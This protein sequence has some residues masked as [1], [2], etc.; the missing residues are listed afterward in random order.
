MAFPLGRGVR[1][2]VAPP[3][4][5]FVSWSVKSPNEKVADRLLN[6]PSGLGKFGSNVNPLSLCNFKTGDHDVIM[7]KVYLPCTNFDQTFLAQDILV[8]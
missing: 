2:S 4:S 5:L 6:Q 3:F 7:H 1:D 8:P